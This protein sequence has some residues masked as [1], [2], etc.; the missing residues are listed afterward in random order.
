MKIPSLMEEIIQQGSSLLLTVA[1]TEE[2]F[3]MHL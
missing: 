1:L 3:A 2:G